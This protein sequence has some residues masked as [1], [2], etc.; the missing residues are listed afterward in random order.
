MLSMAKVLVDTNALIY[1]AK[2][3]TDLN[4]TIDGQILIP[5]LVIKEL[6]VLKKYAVKGEDRAAA[7]LALQLIKHNKWKKI[8]L[9]KGHT[10][11]QLKDYAKEHGCKI[12]TFD[13]N[14]KR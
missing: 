2:K 8:K 5:N 12:Y 1:A 13:K 14:L 4:E 3:R 7:K 9:E 10:D 6:K 11:K